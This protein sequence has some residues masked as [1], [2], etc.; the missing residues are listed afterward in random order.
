M[1]ED[2]V[3]ANCDNCGKPYRVPDPNKIYKCKACGG[4]VCAEPPQ[5][6]QEFDSACPECGEAV[7]SA[8]AFCT[9]CGA[10]IVAQP[11]AAQNAGRSTRRS[12]R[13]RESERAASRELAKAFKFLKI[14]RTWFM[15]NVILHGLL[16][17]LIP[18]AFANPET[19]PSETALAL[20]VHLG[21]T[22]LMLLGFFQVYYRPFV[23]AVVLACMVTLS[24]GYT[25]V[26]SDYNMIITVIS[27]VWAL[28]FWALV[29]PT[30]RVRTLMEKHPDLTITKRITG[31][32]ARRGGKI[33]PQQA[34]KEAE[35]KAWKHGLIS[36]AV[37]AV[38]TIGA[39]F[40]LY[41]DSRMPDFETTWAQ[42]HSDWQKG[43]VDKVS[44]WFGE[45]SRST[46]RAKLEAASENRNWGRSW[47]SLQD[48]EK[49]VNVTDASGSAR[50]VT[51]E[52]V[53]S[54]GEVRLDFHA[55]DGNWNISRLK[56]PDP[57]FE[58][59][60]IEWKRAWNASNFDKLATFYLNSEKMKKSL[61]RIAE[62]RNWEALP[63]ITN[64][65]IDDDR[66]G[67][68]TVYFATD[69][70]EVKVGFKLEMDQWI[71]YTIKP[72]SI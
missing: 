54:G 58:P 12:G 8:E 30:A 52:A 7:G 1:T 27:V 32:R 28:A 3:Q 9:N 66:T 60:L 19:V 34:L 29:V 53:T 42:F 65:V 47:P 63:R 67:V 22:A 10:E 20:A 37:I 51:I 2:R 43:D 72:P 36:V 50:S 6:E 17:L 24:R 13:D 68:R 25:V 21:S 56:L 5:A 38:V 11:A 4:Q 70:G 57:D 59:T 23:W 69:E 61:P 40:A 49:D 39:S 18:F 55:I 71:A 16:L 15:L 35:A 64:T 46:Q 26:V 14:L 44:Q 62:R 33:S 41:Q 45:S 31:S 48:Y